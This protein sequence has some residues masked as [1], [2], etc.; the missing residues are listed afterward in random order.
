MVINPGGR[1]ALIDIVGRD[2]LLAS[3]R[4][5]LSVQSVV[6]TAERRMGKTHVLLKLQHEAPTGQ[7]FVNLDVGGIGSAD[8]FT[9]RVIESVEP[10][11]GQGTRFKNFMGDLAKRTGGAQLGPLKLP[12]FE[13]KS[14]EH[15][16]SQLFQ[17]LDATE[18]L[19]FVFMWDELPWMLQKI[20]ASNAREAMDLLDILRSL[21]Q[22]H[23]KARMIYTGSL[24]LHHIV[25]A[26]RDNGYNND[27]TNDMMIV[28]VPPL[29][30]EDAK[31]LARQLFEAAPLLAENEAVI[32]AIA[33]ATNGV[34][35]WIHWITNDLRRRAHGS[36]STV[37][38]IT[39]ADVV[40]DAIESPNDP[41][42]LRHYLDRTKDYYGTH[43]T[44][45]L[46]LLDVVAAAAVPISVSDTINRAKVKALDLDET[47]WF[48]LIELLQRDHYVVRTRGTGLLGFKFSPVLS[49]WRWHRGIA[50]GSAA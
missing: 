50:I 49:W 24:G 43:R 15:A 23:E 39:I 16:L 3:L 26:L 4:T 1:L 45:A 17:Q 42:H 7:I 2:D 40:Q 29:A 36:A 20:A 22:T 13:G 30:G 41:W 34:G 38:V 32:D 44:A 14:W 12:Q 6:L 46:A 21:R 11:L 10:H 37:T 19:S 33:D 27:P 48:D 9:R 35:F 31:L 5:A 25:R 8:E 47:T 18:R 28:E